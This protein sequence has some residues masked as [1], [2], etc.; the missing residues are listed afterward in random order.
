MHINVMGA[1]SYQIWIILKVHYVVM[2][3]KFENDQINWI[4]KP[5][6]K[7]TTQFHIVILCLNLADPATFLASR[8]VLG[9]LRAAF[10][11]SYGKM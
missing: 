2:G 9:L 5:T 8:S 7:R 6:L 1:T 11:F 3:K 10:L 4:N